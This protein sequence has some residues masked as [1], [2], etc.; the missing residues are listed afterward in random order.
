MNC[1]CEDYL[2]RA[3]LIILTTT[4]DTYLTYILEFGCRYF[5]L[6]LVTYT[7]TSLFFMLRLVKIKPILYFIRVNPSHIF[8]TFLTY[9]EASKIAITPF[10]GN[11][12]FSAG[13]NGLL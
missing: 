5:L 4:Y 11:R 10:I 7:Q 13:N 9:F 6:N 8:Y 12:Y 1:C 3:Q 2:L